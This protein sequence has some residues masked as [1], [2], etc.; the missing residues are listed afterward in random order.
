[1][2]LRS[3]PVLIVGRVYGVIAFNG[4][5]LLMVVEVEEVKIRG[6]HCQGSLLCTSK[7]K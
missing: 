6:G 4:L 2:V 5:P 1:M 7:I 3:N